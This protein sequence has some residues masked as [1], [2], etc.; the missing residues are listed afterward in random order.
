MSIDTLLKKIQRTN[1]DMTRD[2]L[3][4]ELKKSPYSTVAIL[5]CM[6][7]VKGCRN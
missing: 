2:K 7:N 5:M 6:E 4:K 3:I 1:K